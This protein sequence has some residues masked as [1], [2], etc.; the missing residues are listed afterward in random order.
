MFSTNSKKCE[1]LSTSNKLIKKFF[2]I[3]H[4]K[5]TLLNKYFITQKLVCQMVKYNNK[6]FILL[7]KMFS[8]TPIYRLR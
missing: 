7:Q 2:F 6:M 1:Q 3:A 4:F 8:H 5:P